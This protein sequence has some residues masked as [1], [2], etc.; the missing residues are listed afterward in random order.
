MILS[1][2]ESDTLSIMYIVNCLTSLVVK[3]FL[4][5]Y[6]ARCIQH[7]V[8]SMNGSHT[9]SVIC[10]IRYNSSCDKDISNNSACKLHSAQCYMNKWKHKPFCNA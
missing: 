9:L 4:I 8:L 5:S 7:S 2:N 3:I 6:F 10:V 1:E